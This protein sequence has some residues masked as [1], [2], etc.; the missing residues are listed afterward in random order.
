MK[1]IP[2]L[3]ILMVVSCAS[4]KSEYKPCGVSHEKKTWR[5]CDAEKDGNKADM[6]LCYWDIYCKK[7]FFRI[8]KKRVHLFC[9]HG[10][11][12]CMDKYGID[13]MKISN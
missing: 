4:A 6:G 11:L 5:W 13:E 9:A 1:L 3:M 2:V 8:K 7:S 12:Y 10:D